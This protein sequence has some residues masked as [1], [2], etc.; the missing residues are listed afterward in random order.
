MLD[1]TTGEPGEMTIT[2]FVHVKDEVCT[3]QALHCG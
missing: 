3:G 2:S 1:N